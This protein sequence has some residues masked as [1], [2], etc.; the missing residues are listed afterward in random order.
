MKD[1]RPRKSENSSR[2]VWETPKISATMTVQKVNGAIAVRATNDE[3][4]TY[5][6]PS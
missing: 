4:Q 3:V 5:F 2:R 1:Q 6:I